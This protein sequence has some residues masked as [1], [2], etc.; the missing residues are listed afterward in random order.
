MWDREYKDSEG[1]E[2][3]EDRGTRSHG[4]FSQCRLCLKHPSPRPGHPTS[5]STACFSMVDCGWSFRKTCCDVSRVDE[6]REG[7]G[8]QGDELGGSPEIQEL[9][10]VLL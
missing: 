9:G 6:G 8:M 5:C 10:R 1:R 7:E 2:V 3:S 4:C